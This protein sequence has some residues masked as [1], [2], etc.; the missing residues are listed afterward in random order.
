MSEKELIEQAT[1]MLRERLEYVW[2]K[3]TAN[4]VIDL[5]L[6]VLREKNLPEEKLQR[7]QKLGVLT[8]EYRLKVYEEEDLYSVDFWLMLGAI[9]EGKAKVEE[10]FL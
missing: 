5:F 9:W 7:W 1:Q 10:V 2:G 4:E 6:Y 8:P 3:K